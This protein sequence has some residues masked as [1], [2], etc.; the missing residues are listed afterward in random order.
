MM[1]CRIK[2]M[3]QDVTTGNERAEFNARLK[4]LASLAYVEERTVWTLGSGF[5]E[6]RRTK[7]DLTGNRL[8]SNATSTGETS[9]LPNVSDCRAKKS[10]QASLAR[11]CGPE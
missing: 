7:E 8:T 1:A 11:K 5:A 2:A 3:T 4:T 9:E 10:T 6:R